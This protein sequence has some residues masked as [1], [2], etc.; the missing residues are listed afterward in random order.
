LNE[1]LASVLECCPRSQASWPT[2]SQPRYAPR[3]APQAQDIRC[4]APSADTKSQVKVGGRGRDRT[5]G[6]S[7]VKRAV[8]TIQ[9]FYQALCTSMNGLQCSE[10]TSVRC[11]SHH[12]SHHEK[13][14][15]DV[16][17]GENGETDLQPSTTPALADIRYRQSSLCAAQT[18]RRRA[19]QAHASLALLPQLDCRT[20]RPSC[21][22]KRK[23]K[24]DRRPRASAPPC[25]PLGCR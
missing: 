22:R 19:R 9:G 11:S 21:G 4:S 13:R 12:D 6:R 14:S 17:R 24:I 25:R 8:L 16:E 20:G 3:L 7:G 2:S 15:C 18:T 1:F 23:R 10:T 5:C